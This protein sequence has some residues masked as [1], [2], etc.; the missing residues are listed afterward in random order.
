MQIRQHF[1]RAVTA[2]EPVWCYLNT[3]AKDVGGSQMNNNLTFR[4]EAV[5]ENVI[6]TLS[7]SNW[8]VKYRKA[9]NPDGLK[10]FYTRR[11]ADAP[12]PDLQFLSRAWQ[13]ANAKARELGWFPARGQ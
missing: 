8:V 1:A 10:L 4:V 6:V 12:I 3:R 13:L 7:G 9:E 2:L 11:D 5:D